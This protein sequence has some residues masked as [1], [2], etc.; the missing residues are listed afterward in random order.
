MAHTVES[1]QPLQPRFLTAECRGLPAGGRRTQ[2]R[3]PAVGHPLGAD[4]ACRFNCAL[5]FAAQ[6]LQHDL[7]QLQA[8]QADGGAAPQN[9]KQ[10]P[11]LTGAGRAP[12]YRRHANAV[13]R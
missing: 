12:G 9:R 2:I 13:Q 4:V 10:N 5:A 1:S 11:E 8:L 3:A 7:Q 6:A